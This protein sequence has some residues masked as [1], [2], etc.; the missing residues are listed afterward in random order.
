MYRRWEKAEA[1][2]IVERAL[3]TRSKQNK[4]KRDRGMQ[5]KYPDSMANFK[6][7][8]WLP[9]EITNHRFEDEEEEMQLLSLAYPPSHSVRIY[10]GVK[11]YGKHYRPIGDNG[12]SCK[13]YDSGIACLFRARNN[14][15]IADKLSLEVRELLEITEISFGNATQEVVILK[16]HWVDAKWT[17]G[18]DA[19]MKYVDGGISMAKF[20]SL[21]GK[22]VCPYDLHIQFRQ[23]FFPPWD[24]TLWGHVFFAEAQSRRR[25]LTTGLGL[26]ASRRSNPTFE[27]K[28]GYCRG[29]K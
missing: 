23:D 16:G 25:N 11:T 14:G 13:T 19:T 5:W 9:N 1:N 26:R 6:L 20:E 10:P 21:T 4:R 8:D 17:G 18:V 28:H 29:D 22:Q 15:R 27:H 2:R 3:F 24:V 12:T 7:R